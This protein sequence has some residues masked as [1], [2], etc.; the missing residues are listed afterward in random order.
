MT[1][2]VV[3]GAILLNQRY[4]VFPLLERRVSQLTP[5][6]NAEFYW[7]IAAVLTTILVLVAI[8]HTWFDYWE[9]LSN[10]LIHHHGIL[11]SLERWPAPG[12]RF[13]KEIV[14]VFEFMLLGSGRLVITPAGEGRP[15]VLDDVPRINRVEESMKEVLGVTE[16]EIHHD[17]S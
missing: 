15:I 17:R 9:V 3:L 4:E 1:V 6:A 10:E 2:A 12:I 11:G 5:E 16:V 14:D 7:V 8:I 13:D